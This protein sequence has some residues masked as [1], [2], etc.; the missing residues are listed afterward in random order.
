MS[1]CELENCIDSSRAAARGQ[2][3]AFECEHLQAVQHGDPFNE[4]APLEDDVLS[5]M[6][7]EYKWLAEARKTECIKLHNDAKSKGLCPVY[8]WL[9]PKHMSQRFIYYSVHSNVSHYWSK[10]N[11]CIVFYDTVE[12]TWKCACSS[13]KRPCVHKAMAQWF[14]LQSL[15]EILSPQ[16][17]Q[18][19]AMENDGTGEVYNYYML[20][21]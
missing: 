21:V 1:R 14:T 6:V 9:P 19:C 8:P 5:L 4:Q 15:P 7:T 10:L 12:G 18:T 16:R 11:R 20:Y 13:I 2:H 3:P 17:E